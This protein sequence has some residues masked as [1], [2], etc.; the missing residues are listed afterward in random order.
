M[1]F[2][3]IVSMYSNMCVNVHSHVHTH[4]YKTR[5]ERPQVLKLEYA[6]MLTRMF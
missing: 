4:F 5:W 1:H 6:C 3:Y 2:V